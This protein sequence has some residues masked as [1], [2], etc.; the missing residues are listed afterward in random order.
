MSSSETLSFLVH[1]STVLGIFQLKSHRH[2][3]L[4]SCLRNMLQ[5]SARGDRAMP[6]IFNGRCRGRELGAGRGRVCARHRMAAPPWCVFTGSTE[7]SLPKPTEAGCG[8]AEQTGTVR[9]VEKL[10]GTRPRQLPGSAPRG[11]RRG[12]MWLTSMS[13]SALGTGQ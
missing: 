9:V 1:K 4:F 2:F 11:A 10:Q 6:G 5:S 7:Q 3:P 13:A 8:V 12:A